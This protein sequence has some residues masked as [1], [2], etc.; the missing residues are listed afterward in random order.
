MD[1]A[2][3]S[4][5]VHFYG[6][7]HFVAIL[8]LP[9]LIVDVSFAG[10]VPRPLHTGAPVQFTEQALQQ[11]T[12]MGIQPIGSA[13]VPAQI[14]LEVAHAQKDE[15]RIWDNPF[16][17]VSAENWAI[18]ASHIPDRIQSHVLDLRNASGFSSVSEV[19]HLICQLGLDVKKN[20]INL[21][22]WSIVSE[23]SK[24]LGFQVAQFIGDI[25]DENLVRA[26]LR[27]RKQ[28]I[29]TGT[30]TITTPKLKA[31]NIPDVFSS[32]GDTLI[33]DWLER[34]FIRRSGFGYE[35]SNLGY[36]W[37]QLLSI[38]SSHDLT[39]DKIW[40]PP[41]AKESNIV[42]A[43]EI[44]R[45]RAISKERPAL[46]GEVLAI[47]W[48]HIKEHDWPIAGVAR[49]L[50]A[51]IS[52]LSGRENAVDVFLRK[53]ASFP[54]TEL[55]A[56]RDYFSQEDAVQSIDQALRRR[57][58][59]KLGLVADDSA[60]EMESYIIITKSVI[61]WVFGQCISN[62]TVA[63]ENFLATIICIK[64]ANPNVWVKIRQA[65]HDDGKLRK[66][67]RLVRIDGDRA[68]PLQMKD[69]MDSKA[70]YGL[71]KFVEV[72]LEGAA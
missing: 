67:Y 47:I 32:D 7:R 19:L 69:T 33:Q 55:E 18:V 58:G 38:K 13:D 10:F 37:V 4:A 44:R 52:I 48:G 63:A 1:R 14:D 29:G 21:F 20:K 50:C 59:R 8:L 46:H 53:S 65:F 45:S 11:P 2:H 61:S 3:C 70:K 42:A 36:L 6:L 31:K 56:L 51:Q 57:R 9:T 34:Y 15:G 43:R 27:S 64:D 41:A 26:L 40:S 72:S 24:S 16:V 54:P 35:I 28:G 12:T 39:K 60:T 71:Q 30:N 66:G 17:W 22:F 5:P 25:P 62:P 23:L 49:V 68:V